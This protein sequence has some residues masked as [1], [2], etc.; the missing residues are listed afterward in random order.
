MLSTPSPPARTVGVVHADKS[1]FVQEGAP[2]TG[3]APERE[4]H[5]GADLLEPDRILP[6]R[7]PLTPG[8]LY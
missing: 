4:L 5:Q 1:A 7:R 2:L 8:K 3:G 6:H